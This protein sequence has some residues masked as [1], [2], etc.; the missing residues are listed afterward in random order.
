M[1]SNIFVNKDTEVYYPNQYALQSSDSDVTI[2]PGDGTP[3]AIRSIKAYII[4]T[5][6]QKEY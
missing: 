2:Q 5:S 6:R 1:D 4:N 3:V